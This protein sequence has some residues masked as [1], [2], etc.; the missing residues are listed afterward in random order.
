MT[1]EDDKYIVSACDI[2]SEHKHCQSSFYTKWSYVAIC[3]VVMFAII[4]IPLFHVIPS[5]SNSKNISYIV[6]S[7]I[8]GFSINSLAVAVTSQLLYIVNWDNINDNL[9]TSKTKL[10]KMS[11]SNLN[12]H[13]M[14]VLISLVLLACITTVPWTGNK[15]YLYIMSCFVPIVFFFV[16]LCVPVKDKHGKHTTPM[17]KIRL[18]YGKQSTFT[19]LSLLLTIFI[20]AGLYTLVMRGNL[21]ELVKQ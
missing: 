10:K 11:I 6:F 7:I 19:Q 2:Y 1:K 3:C 15:L 5:L 4:F 13:L 9:I 8:I 21:V 18:I 20:S 14:P 16:W 12:N 17:N